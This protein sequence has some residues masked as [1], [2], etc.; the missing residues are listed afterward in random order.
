MP[1]RQ[2]QR[3]QQRTR[4][5]DDEEGGRSW[6]LRAAA[7]L[8]QLWRDAGKTA[9]ARDLLAPVAAWFPQDLD[10]PGLKAARAVL[11]TPG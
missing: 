7:D 4:D 10:M 11:D 8:A 5:G 6:E 9:E 1:S 2:A 3:D